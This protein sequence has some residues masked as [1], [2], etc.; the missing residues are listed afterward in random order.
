MK[1]KIYYETNEELWNKRTAIHQKSDFYDLP[2]FKAGKSS[3]MSTELEELGDVNGKSILHLQCHFGMDSL[4]LAK[5]GAKVTGVDFSSEAIKLAKSLNQELKL[6][7]RFI[8]SNVYD[9]PKVL[10]EQFDI[11]FTSYGVLC[12]L[13][14]LPAWAAIIARYLKSGGTFYMVEFHPILMLFEFDSGKLGIEYTYFFEEKPFEEM[15]EGTYANEDAEIHHKEY[16]WNHGLGEIITVLAAEG[17]QIEFVH[18]FPFSHYNCFPNMSQK[19]EDEWFMT[20]FENLV[21]LMFSI[22]VKKA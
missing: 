8:Q 4:S 5:K 11:I 3:L 9:L 7:A 16:F 10:D 17:L 15:A 12:W 22:K 2:A 21:P 14:D 20:N 19:S 6:D 13:G 1:N 18:E